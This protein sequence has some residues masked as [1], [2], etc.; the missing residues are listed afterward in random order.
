[1][2]PRVVDQRQKLVRQAILDFVVGG[3]VVL[4]IME[5]LEDLTALVADSDRVRIF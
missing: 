4:I 1:M 3:E 5:I 2:H